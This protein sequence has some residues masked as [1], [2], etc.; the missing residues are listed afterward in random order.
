MPV[1]GGQPNDALR[2]ST[3]TLERGLEILDCYDLDHWGRTLTE[4]CAETG[5]PKATAFRLLKTLEGRG[6]LTMDPLTNR[7]CLGPSMM[8][9]AYVMVTH[10]ELARLAH[11]LLEKLA[12]ATLETAVLT[13][14]SAERTIALDYVA[15]PLPVKPYIRAGTMLNDLFNA[16]AQA[17]LAFLPDEERRSIVAR[18]KGTHGE[19]G[20]TS[21]DPLALEARLYEV[22]AEGIAYDLEARV[23]GVCGAAAPV[24]DASGQIRAAI[25]IIAPTDRFMVG[26][27][28]FVAPIR[29]AA[30]AMSRLLG[31]KKEPGA[32]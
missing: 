19:S 29:E 13:G 17:Y 24:F 28:R 20:A 23:K 8:K 4:I 14:W 9:A 16:H 25:G 22:R 7:Y 18:R 30:E 15:T 6:Y 26:V 10:S 21:F 1:A 11:P 32:A 2:V 3:R 12:E 5:L 27:E 31:H